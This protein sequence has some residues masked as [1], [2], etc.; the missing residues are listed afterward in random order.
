MSTDTPLLGHCP[1]C[2]GRIAG[3]QV[4]IEYQRGTET[5]VYAECSQ[6]RAVVH[7]S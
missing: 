1:K 3:H 5:A 4:L 6:C 7:P 2:A